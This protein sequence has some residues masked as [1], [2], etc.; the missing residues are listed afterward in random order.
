MG[1][2]L[3]PVLDPAEFFGL[4][5]INHLGQLFYSPCG[6]S[7]NCPMPE[8]MFSFRHPDGMREQVFEITRPPLATEQGLPVDAI[9]KRNNLFIASEENH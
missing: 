3:K 8:N 6:L 9:G 7:N 1:P 4:R 2:R 5:S